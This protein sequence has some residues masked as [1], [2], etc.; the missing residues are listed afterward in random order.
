ML[1]YD[2][3]GPKS[4]CSAVQS[5]RFH[6]VLPRYLQRSR[7]GMD[8]TAGL[9]ACLN[10]KHE[11]RGAFRHPRGVTPLRDVAGGDACVPVRSGRCQ[12][13]KIISRRWITKSEIRIPHSQ[14]GRPGRYRARFCLVAAA[15]LT[16]I[17]FEIIHGILSN[18]GPRSSR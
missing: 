16:Y 2:V 11:K 6:R 1:S 4:V 7:S 14:I 9:P 8:W 15:H 5:A 12:S 10:A 13:S 3:P 18:G 17:G